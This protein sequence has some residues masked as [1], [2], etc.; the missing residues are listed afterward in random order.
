MRGATLDL[1]R[2]LRASHS[3]RL[4]FS[5]E[6]SPKTFQRELQALS[7]RKWKRRIL[8]AKMLISHPPTQLPFSPSCLSSNSPPALI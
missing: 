4:K 3:R 8:C 7:P 5:A 1:C 6:K 2:P